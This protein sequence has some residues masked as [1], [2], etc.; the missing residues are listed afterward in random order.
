MKGRPMR[1]EQLFLGPADGVR[2]RLW[3]QQ[4]EDGRREGNNATGYSNFGK[5]VRMEPN[6]RIQLLEA[7]LA[8]QLQWIG[9]SDTKGAQIFTM[10]V[11]MIG[12][13]AAVSPD[14]AAEWSTA[15]AVSASL[16]IVACAAAFAHLLL[17]AFP[18]T[19]GPKGS[20][21]YCGGVSERVQDQFCRAFRE[22]K[23]EDYAHDLATQC[24]RNAVIAC[25][26]FKWIQRALIALYAAVAPWAIAVWLLYRA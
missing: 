1:S 4:M 25:T 15:Q 7:N 14:T 20:M 19:D 18:R 6:D 24:H 5:G 11:A 9:S 10:A 13:L 16:T 2:Q 17:A 12:L 23:L 21:V 8:R 3:R 26:K 22:L